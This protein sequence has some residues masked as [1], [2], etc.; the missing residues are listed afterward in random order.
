[1]SQQPSQ[2]WNYQQYEESGQR[3]QQRH[4]ASSVTDQAYY[5]DGSKYVYY[6]NLQAGLQFRQGQSL[7]NHSR[8][9]TGMFTS[10]GLP[11]DSI[12]QSTNVPQMPTYIGNPS[13]QPSDVLLPQQNL[14]TQ[15]QQ[16]Q[17][18]SLSQYSRQPTQSQRELVRQNSVQNMVGVVPVEPL[19]YTQSQIYPTEIIPHL[20]SSQ[21]NIQQTSLLEDNVGQLGNG[22]LRQFSRMETDE[23][24]TQSI[25]I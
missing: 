17:Q 16:Y 10:G 8:L 2:S 7:L 23:Q 13:Q 22:R 25:A 18:Q 20:F 5:W 3:Q 14:F 11:T 19:D 12:S 4:T 24:S 15:Q 6:Q 1:M 9:P 21:S